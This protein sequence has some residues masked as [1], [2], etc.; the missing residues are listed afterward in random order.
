[1]LSSFPSPSLH[2]LSTSPAPPLIGPRQSSPRSALGPPNDSATIT[3]HKF[4]SLLSI[5]D[6]LHCTHY[7]VWWVGGIASWLQQEQEVQ[8][9]GGGERRRPKEIGRST[10]HSRRSRGDRPNGWGLPRF[11]AWFPALASSGKVCAC[12]RRMAWKTDKIYCHLQIR[13]V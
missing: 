13:N 3:T 6:P 2:L 12:Q 4:P 1:M 8:A 9:G 11:L 10:L 5:A 7:I